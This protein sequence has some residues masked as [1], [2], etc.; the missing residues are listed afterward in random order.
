[1]KSIDEQAS[2]FVI[3]YG[4]KLRQLPYSDLYTDNSTQEGE[5]TEIQTPTDLSSYEFSSSRCNYDKGIIRVHTIG[6]KSGAFINTSFND[7]F[8]IYPD[9]KVKEIGKN[10]EDWC[11]RT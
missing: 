4:D 11:G 10:D 5:V 1:M 9:G 3:Q 7:A 8:D 2:E 6:N